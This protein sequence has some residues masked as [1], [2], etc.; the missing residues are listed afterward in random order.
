MSQE[1]SRTTANSHEP[2]APLKVLV[3]EDFEDTRFLMRLE[4]EKRGFR[5]VEA[6]DGEQGVGYAASE[7]PDIILMD[8]GLPQIDGIEAT[9]R[10][11]A[12]SSMR[13]VLIVALTAHHETEYRAQALAA[14]C[15]AY[16][17][18]PVDFDWLIDL[19]G[20]LLP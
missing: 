3:V 19:L 6:T 10:I 15:D 1:T 14:G 17:T 12:D 4:L 13:D 8:I 16:L 20:R 11:R 5:V 9:R 18:K 7:R 2:A